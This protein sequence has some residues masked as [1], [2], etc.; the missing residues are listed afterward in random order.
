MPRCGPGRPRR[1]TSRYEAGSAA[2]ELA[3]VAPLL[4]LLALVAVAFGTLAGARLDA[5]EAAHQAARA[6]SLARSP[7]QA[8]TAAEQAAR[9]RLAG[10][11]S[12][13]TNPRVTPVLSDFAPSGTVRV[14]VICRAALNAPGMPDV[15]VTATAASVV[16]RYR[17]VRGAQP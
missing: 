13:C 11:G 2:T 17:G 1:P 6:A 12:S 4:I 16:D 15:T 10:S 14:T 8:R 3:L 7:D 9:R 5:D